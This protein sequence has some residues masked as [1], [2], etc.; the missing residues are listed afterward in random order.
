MSL[1]LRSIA[2][3][4]LLFY[5]LGNAGDVQAYPN[6]IS[7][8][9]QSC[10]SCHYNPYG[11]GPLTDY[12]R[13]VGATAIADRLLSKRKVK[14]DQLADTANFL[15]GAEEPEWLR[16]SFDYRGMY[17]QR[18]YGEDNAKDHY[19]HMDVSAAL[20]AK[21]FPRDR[22]VLVGQIAYA[23]VP[24]AFQNTPQG[25]DMEVYRS[26]EHYVGFRVT[27]ELGIYAGLMDKVFGI[28]VPDHTAFSRTV[29]GLTQNDQTH[30]VLLHY[31]NKTFELGFQ[32]F[33]GNLV[34]DDKLRQKGVTTQLEFNVSETARVGG[35]FLTSA[36]EYVGTTMYSAQT[37]IGMGKGNSLMLEIGEAVKK[38]K[39]NDAIASSQ[40]VFMQNHL[41]FRRG[42]FGLVTLEYVKPDAS[43]DPYT[44]RVGPGLQFFPFQ[45]LELR[46]D[47]YNTTRVDAAGASTHAL[48][49][50][51]QIHLWL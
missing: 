40:Y 35:S 18:N 43:L 20:V 4:V 42:L 28:R 37:R 39:A 23:P 36:S 1:L 31:F 2:S 19:L 13:V 11:N 33:V 15:Y 30:G 24:L 17:M 3:S 51:A 44:Y 14:E 12:G 38:I 26:R 6:Y 9:Y 25:D 32:P 41:L 22:L 48:D 50:T 46:T 16:P 45:R 21:F 5:L 7:F 34:Q 47:V 10:L 8:G 49:L 27:K 29:T